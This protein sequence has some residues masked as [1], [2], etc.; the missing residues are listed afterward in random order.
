VIV[1]SGASEVVAEANATIPSGAI[2]SALDDVVGEAAAMMAAEVVKS[3]AAPAR[4]EAVVEKDLVG[5][6]T[7]LAAVATSSEDH[8][9]LVS[10]VNEAN[11]MN[12]NS[13]NSVKKLK[14]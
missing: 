6:E 14:K 13:W 12:S 11:A 7:K 9:K 3:Q 4:S 10:R 1:E 2:A 5:G 8:A